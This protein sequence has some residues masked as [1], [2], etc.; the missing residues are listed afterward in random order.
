M[1]AEIRETQTKLTDC[2]EKL[3]YTTSRLK[4]LQVEKEML[5]AR[6]M[7]ARRENDQDQ[8]QIE[9]ELDKMRQE[10]ARLQVQRDELKTETDQQQARER[11]Y[12]E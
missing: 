2:T 4:E 11:Q 9:A 8:I 3:N 7:D 1:D 12:R 5:Q 10:F 6:Q